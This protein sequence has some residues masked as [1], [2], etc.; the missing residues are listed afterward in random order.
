[1]SLSQRATCH[2][3]SG[4]KGSTSLLKAVV[5]LWHVEEL[6]VRGTPPLLPWIPARWDAQPGSW[7][8]DAGCSRRAAAERMVGQAMLTDQ[9]TGWQKED[10]K[11]EKGRKGG[12]EKKTEKKGKK[13]TVGEEGKRSKRGSIF[14]GEV[15]E[16]SVR[17]DYLLL[18]LILFWGS[19]YVS[20]WYSDDC[21]DCLKSQTCFWL[22]FIWSLFFPVWAT[23]WIYFVFVC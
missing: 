12:R 10:T 19:P 20:C 23:C 3:L 8:L 16:G 4:H 9:W 18:Y 2:I 22:L 15:G 1:M 5:G 6:S 21:F 11:E 17:L 14:F 13:I 7:G